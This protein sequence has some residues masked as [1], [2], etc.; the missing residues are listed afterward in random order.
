MREKGGLLVFPPI[1]R[2]ME[3]S[4]FEAAV[5]GQLSVGDCHA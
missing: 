4:F 5:Q 2:A 1:A 3:K